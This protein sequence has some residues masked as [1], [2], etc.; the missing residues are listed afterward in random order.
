MFNQVLDV[1]YTCLRGVSVLR[2]YGGYLNF[3]LLLLI[4]I[5]LSSAMDLNKLY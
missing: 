2:Y 5:L 1:Q 3:F 4:V